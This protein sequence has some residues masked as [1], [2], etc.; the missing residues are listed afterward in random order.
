MNILLLGP[1]W[2]NQGIRTFLEA[3]GCRVTTY[4]EP[5]T[6]A[7]C[8]QLSTDWIVSN[9]Y[10]PII[11]EPVIGAYHRRII[12]LH[13]A[14]LPHGRGIYPNLWGLVEGRQTGVSIHFIDA[15]ID[16]G[17]VIARTPI[18]PQEGDTL[19]SFYDLLLQRTEQLFL[20]LWPAISTGQCAVTP[21]ET[22]PVQYR[23]RLAGEKLM[24]CFEQRWQTPAAAAQSCGADFWLGQQFW[25]K[26]H[27]ATRTAE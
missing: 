3:R 27:G 26:W 9:G 25:Q 20:D 16:T 10:A 2:R 15:G 24:D 4:T 12:N 6:L 23:N 19:Q 13:P 18:S 22:V 1:D 21:Q 11:K 8:R 5:L 7:F 14:Y 17:E